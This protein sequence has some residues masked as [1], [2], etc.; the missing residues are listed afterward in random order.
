MN[1]KQKKTLLRILITLACFI[2]LMICEKRIAGLPWYLQALF[3]LPPYLLIGH[4]VILRAL[5]NIRHGQ[6]FDE[7]FLMM[8]ATFA[9][10]GMG[11]FEE[12]L[13]VMLFY[14][15]GEL[16]QSYAV[17]RSRASIT[18]MMS[19]APEYAGLEAEDGSVTEVDPEDVEVGSV[20]VIRPGEKIPLD[21]TVL[22]GESFLDTAA[23]TGESVPRR[24]CAGDDVISGCVNGA[25][26]LRVR[27]NRKYEDSTVARILDLVENAS[28]KKA[29]LENFIT[30]FAK[31][32]TP[33]V[34][35]GAA[36]LALI[37]PVVRLAMGLA[38]A[39]GDWIGRAC[40]FLIVSCPCALV[41]SVPLGFFGGIGAASRIG[42]LVK[43][44][45]FL[46]L[47]AETTTV[48]MD[49]T[50]TLTKGEFAV[51]GV[52][53]AE[54]SAD[55][56]RQLLL[57]AALGESFSTHPIAQSVLA[58]YKKAEEEGGEPLPTAMLS[59]MQ[60]I[61]GHG[62]ISRYQG[63]ELLVG[64]AALLSD[65]GVEMYK[66]TDDIKKLA[67][68]V[69][70][71]ALDGVYRGALV[72][73]DSV[74]EG[75]AEAVAGMRRAGVRRVVMLTGDRE[76]AARAVCESLSLD[77]Y[78]AELLPGDKV[79]AVEKLIADNAGSGKLAFVG[80]GINDAPVL[81]RADVGIAMGSLGSDAAI[82]A[83]DIVLMDDDVTKI[84]RLMQIGR[85]TLRIVRQNVVLALGVKFA[86]L[87]LGALGIATMWLA[88]FAD[89][90]VAVLAI[91]NSMRAL[92]G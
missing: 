62:T 14:Q 77:T 29:K 56:E 1:R 83:A 31:Y 38:P 24:A 61:A 11:E 30:R 79:D 34:T 71:V 9:A 47:I 35:I 42:V 64:N 88:V 40:I 43:G 69:V 44:S 4:D 91:L 18:Q 68:T 54:D 76:D 6:V 5:K 3:Y 86:V 17:G 19:I 66:I 12:A 59:D 90:G 25:G 20:I 41:I 57:L 82:E 63:R 49:K 45:N 48:V 87:L 60:E 16:F 23:L 10:I 55:A 52:L 22:S 50:G 80:D 13:A 15:V 28:S 27:V 7:N 92:K 85:R 58:A 70:L 32:Y 37:P 65:N 36:L 26:T 81:M 75:A 84:A 46:E 72:I 67:G 2:V 21:G 89:V 73:S 39:W 8:V 53:P 78:Y 33:A 51:T 74:K